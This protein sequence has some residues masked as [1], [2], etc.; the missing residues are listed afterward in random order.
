MLFITPHFGRC[1][2]QVPM[3]YYQ[4]LSLARHCKTP[5]PEHQLKRQQ[6]N[7]FLLLQQTACT[8]KQHFLVLPVNP[9]SKYLL[10]HAA[11]YFH[12]KTA[13]NKRLLG[14]Y[15]KSKLSFWKFTVSEYLFVGSRNLKKISIRSVEPKDKVTGHFSHTKM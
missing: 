6:Q 13:M 5:I 11:H 12:H 7:T 3:T 14:F 1:G 4:R 9:G 8:A 15:S 10:S 2:A